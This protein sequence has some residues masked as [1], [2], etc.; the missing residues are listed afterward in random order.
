M[1]VSRVRSSPGIAKLE[2]S[3]AP[4]FSAEERRLNAR[5]EADLREYLGEQAIADSAR[6]RLNREPDVRKSSQPPPRPDK[7]RSIWD[8]PVLP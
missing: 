7:Q 2:L 4:H 5:V 1:A 8:I 3:R 6:I